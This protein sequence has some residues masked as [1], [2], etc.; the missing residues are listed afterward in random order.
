MDI[1]RHFLNID[2]T[3]HGL[4][5]TGP[6][7]KCFS[8]SIRVVL[9]Q[10][11]SSSDNTRTPCPKNFRAKSLGQSQSQRTFQAGEQTFRARNAEPM[12]KWIQ[13]S[14]KQCGECF[15][16]SCDQEFD[17]KTLMPNIAELSNF[18]RLY[19]MSRRHRTFG[20]YLHSPW[21][22]ASLSPK[23]P[24]PSFQRIS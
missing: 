21:E 9:T 8:R 12:L 20:N 4:I 23:T 15:S 14:R 5:E 16:K 3:R 2:H 24:N 10:C 6:I 18:S 13:W 11:L 17:T 1:R 22:Q 19:S 7:L